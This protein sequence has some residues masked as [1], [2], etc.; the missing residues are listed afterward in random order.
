[1]NGFKSKA[2]W[3]LLIIAILYIWYGHKNPT[4]VYEKEMVEVPV[5][6][7]IIKTK[8]VAVACV[9]TIVYEKVE[10]SERLAIP[11]SIRIDATKQITSAV[12][13]GPYLGDTT[14][15]S[16]LDVSTGATT[17]FS[18]REPLPFFAIENITEIGIGFGRMQGGMGYDIYYRLDFLRIGKVHMNAYIETS[19]LGEGKAMLRGGYR[20]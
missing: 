13:V 20:F 15:T 12:K 14:V 11:E 2:Q 19:S 4:I 8:L 6:E 18:R 3:I 7:E 5:H 1:M 17:M 10:A 9:N 16:V